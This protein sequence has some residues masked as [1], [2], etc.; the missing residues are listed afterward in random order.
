MISILILDNDPDF[1]EALKI[2][3][4]E[5]GY[6]VMTAPSAERCIEII[7][8]NDCDLLIIDLAESPPESADL[9]EVIAKH[10][11]KIDIIALVKHGDVET[12]IR[13]VKAGARNVYEKPLDPDVFLLNL[14]KFEHNLELVAKLKRR[15][16]GDTHSFD[17]LASKN[18]RMQ[19][20]LDEVRSFAETDVNILITGESGTGKGLLAKTIYASSTRSSQSFVEI[21]CSAIPST[22]LESELFGHERGAFTDARETRQ[23]LFD[24]ADKGTLFLDEISTMDYNMQSKLLKVIEDFKFFRVG[25]RREIEVNTRIIAATNADLIA[26]VEE[27]KFRQ[28]LYYRL[29]VASVLLP[30]LRDRKE[31]IVD[32]FL[33]FIEEFN[34]TLGKNVTRIS[35]EV[36]DVLREYPWPG[37]IRELRNICERIMVIISGDVILKAFLPVEIISGAKKRWPSSSGVFKTLRDIEKDH[38]L[39]TI[40]E[41]KGNR[42]KAAKVLGISR[43]TLISK[44]KEYNHT[45]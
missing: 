22:L 42:S 10:S 45:S 27:R 16:T 25:G 41:M 34:L 31:D 30:P 38:I 36:A 20:I 32:L 11:K 6:P 44:L 14:E 21:N 8:H 13:A 18:I 28:D 17:R 24:L 29:N 26:L 4:E 33:K 7:K 15:K 3:L 2:T 19:K 43:T 5:K 40:E 9:L 35:P 12:A 39:A 23:G 1:A 37:N